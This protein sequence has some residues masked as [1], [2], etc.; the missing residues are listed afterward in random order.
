MGDI[1]SS[2]CA[3]LGTL[4]TKSQP[5]SVIMDDVFSDH[6]PTSIQPPQIACRAGDVHASV[7][8]SEISTG[9]L[10]GVPGACITSIASLAPRPYEGGG[11]DDATCA[12]NLLTSAITKAS[13]RAEVQS[14]VASPPRFGRLFLLKHEKMQSKDNNTNSQGSGS[15]GWLSE[16]RLLPSSKNSS[17]DDNNA[18]Q[19]RKHSKVLK[20]SSYSARYNYT[21]SQSH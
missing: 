18:Y 4:T 10:Y 2:P 20:S 15:K 19:S 7:R 17:S 14:T 11:L 8:K 5:T 1:P 3:N 21:R 9:N 12:S 6:S 13:P 16:L